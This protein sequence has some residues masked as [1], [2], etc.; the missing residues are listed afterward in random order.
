MRG[1]LSILFVAISIV[2]AAALQQSVAPRMS[3]FGCSPDF[4]LVVLGP[5]SM[6][7][8]PLSGALIGFLCGL[9]YGAAAGANLAHYAISRTLA[10]FFGS[11]SQGVDIHS[12]VLLAAGVTALVTIVARLTLMFLAPPP[13]IWPFLA[14]TIGSALYN[15]V[16]AMPFHAL[17]RRLFPPKRV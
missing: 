2:L 5:A 6:S 4:L 7:V 11:L 10:G 3:L 15:G 17:L 9:V 12:G 1:P 16:L 8:R 14:A 13:A